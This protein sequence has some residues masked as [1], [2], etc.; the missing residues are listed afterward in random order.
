MKIYY[1]ERQRVWCPPGLPPLRELHY[2]RVIE[3]YL[4]CTAG[5][6]VV[7]II[8]VVST[9]GLLSSS[10]VTSSRSLALALEIAGGIAVA[11]SL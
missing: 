9:V 8:L 11:P 10:S 4:I 6:L 7:N 1:L 5:L 2:L 3:L